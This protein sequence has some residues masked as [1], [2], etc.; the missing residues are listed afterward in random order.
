MGIGQCRQIVRSIC[1]QGTWSDEIFLPW[2]VVVKVKSMIGAQ[3]PEM[4]V[5]LVRPAK[6]FMEHEYF[7]RAKDVFDYHIWRTILMMITRTTH[8]KSLVRLLKF[9]S[10]SFCWTNTIVSV[11]TCDLNIDTTLLPLKIKQTAHSLIA[12]A[13]KLVMEGDMTDSSI[14]ENG[15]SAIRSVC[16]LVIIVAIDFFANNTGNTLV[17]ENTLAWKQLLTRENTTSVGCL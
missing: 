5:K 12:S 17:R 8:A 3:I 16:L 9:H 1:P 2:G 7:C 13:I 11:M 4:L 6:S 14:T 10:E 15:A